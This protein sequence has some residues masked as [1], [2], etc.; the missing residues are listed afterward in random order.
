MP[1]TE[2]RASMK[3]QGTTI[4]VIGGLLVLAWLTRF[5]RIDHWSLFS[6]E[7]W[8]AMA[9]RDGSLWDMLRYVYF[10]ESH[11]PGYHLLMRTVQA[12]FGFSDTALRMPSLLA[13]VALVY[14]V[15]HYGC[16]WLDRRTGL[17]A[18]LLVCGSYY[19]IY[20]SQEARAYALLMLAVMLYVHAL[21]AFLLAKPG[22]HRPVALLIIS[23]TAAAYLHYAGVVYVACGGL[24]VLAAWLKTRDA[25]LLRAA[26]WAYGGVL[27]LYSPWLPGFFYHL[28]YGPV[29]DWQQVPDVKRLWETWR[30]IAG[31]NPE[32]A[33]LLALA[34]MTGVALLWR[35]QP[36][37]AVILLLLTV[38]P[39]MIFFIKSQFSMPV[40]NTRSFTPAI[41]LVALAAAWAL[42]RWVA[43]VPGRYGQA[44]FVGMLVLV[45]LVQ[46][47]GNLKHQL[48][49]GGRFK[50]HY[51]QAV[52]RVFRDPA[53]AQAAQLPLVLDH[54]FFN[55][56]IEQYPPYQ[57]SDLKFAEPGELPVLEQQLAERG[58]TRFY[59]LSLFSRGQ[60][61][62]PLREALG[63]RFQR[64]CDSELNRVRVTG[65]TRSSVSTVSLPSC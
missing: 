32:R 42:T 24:L 14:A 37:M 60:P 59:F 13:G 5:Y 33:L 58:I 49:T 10:H 65:Y 36:W 48:Y 26:L 7:I 30:L 50:Q 9:S 55:H 47:T 63:T 54:D 35:R 53:V 44:T 21:T 15:Y 12:W 2:G 8:S 6:D 19:A 43:A 34:A 41:P 20:Y 57:R 22:E 40:Y 28:V 56:Y 18:A 27:L 11:P 31:H 23:A 51:R 3:K 17:L 1:V 46:W 62:P 29:E 64:F 39:V 52:E 25:S 4:L 38:L 45:C 16:R 61:E